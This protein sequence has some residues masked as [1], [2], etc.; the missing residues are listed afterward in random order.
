[1]IRALRAEFYKSMRN[2]RIMYT[3]V[4][5]LPIS[6]FVLICLLTIATMVNPNTAPTF[7]INWKQQIIE[8]L[9][10]T[11]NIIAYM[12]Y[13]VLA[14][15]L[16]GR[17]YSWNTWKNVLPR[18]QR[19]HIIMSKFIL[20]ILAIF[21]SV[22]LI[23]FM[24]YVGVL[25]YTSLTDIVLQSG[26]FGESGLA[27]P[28]QYIAMTSAVFCSF[29]FGALYSSVISIQTGSMTNGVIYGGG[30]ALF[31]TLAQPAMNLISIILNWEALSL[32]PRYLPNHQV[33]NIIN[34]VNTGTT[35]TWSLGISGMILAIWGVSLI[36]LV[37][38]LFNRKDIT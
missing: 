15:F 26:V 8:S 36:G 37:I 28:A 38:V 24:T 29:L 31:D 1:M 32:A 25:I 19:T 21:L 30:L 18:T 11:N 6:V 17:E 4:I 3:S 14:A 9:A 23:A 35:D 16:F 7:S 5:F 20:I 10:I 13:V 2:T 12:I 22:H 27:F 34:W 33:G